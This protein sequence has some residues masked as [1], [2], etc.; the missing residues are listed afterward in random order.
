MHIPVLEEE[1]IEAFRPC[2]LITHVDATLGAGG[3]ALALL[4]HHPEIEQL[5]GIDQDTSAIEIACERLAPY[6]DQVEILEGNFRDLDKLLEGKSVDGILIDCGVSSMQLDTG[7]R[8][9]SFSYDAPLD[10][11][12][13][14]E[15]KVSAKEII[16]KWSE[17]ELIALFRD[18]GEIPSYRAVTRRIIKEREHKEIATTGQLVELLRG[19]ARTTRG[20]K[21]HP[22]TLVFQALRIAVNDELGALE[23][24]LPKAIKHLNPGGR[25]AVIAFHSLED[26]IVKEAFRKLAS[27]FEEDPTNPMTGRKEKEPLVERVTRRPLKPSREEQKKNPRSRSAR[28]RIVEKL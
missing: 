10:M 23:S 6:K 7:E 13:N 8:G 18:Y 11:R 5:I 3:H 15:A 27:N 2:K 22:M 25:L 16:N 24:V 1:I 14:K 26:R 12:M 28:L 20:K 17:E 19:V 21:I 4:K 9:F